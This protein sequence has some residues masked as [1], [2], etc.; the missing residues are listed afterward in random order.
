MNNLKTLILSIMAA[1]VVGCQQAPETFF[2][3]INVGDNVETCMAKGAVRYQNGYD[4][5]LANNY[6]ADSFFTYNNVKFD[7]QNIINE[8]KMSIHRKDD[9]SAAKDLFSFMT[10]YFCQR[11]SGMKTNKISE[12]KTAENGQ[13]VYNQDR[14]TNTWETDRIRIILTSYHNTLISYPRNVASSNGAVVFNWTA[15]IAEND[16]K[17][18]FVELKICAK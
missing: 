16:I 13:I 9:A 10:Q 4:Y 7:S 12:E 5:K 11:Y 3:N 17:G 15:D 14:V 2:E 8:V 1:A 18:S 6:I